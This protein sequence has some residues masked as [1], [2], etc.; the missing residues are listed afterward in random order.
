MDDA[1]DV[2]SENARDLP[3]V[4]RPLSDPTAVVALNLVAD[5]GDL[6][7]VTAEGLRERLGP[8]GDVQLLDPADPGAVLR[9]DTPRWPVGPLAAV[10]ARRAGVV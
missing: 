3:G 7:A 1:A 6:R 5:A 9:R 4:Y 8:W 10:G 2:N